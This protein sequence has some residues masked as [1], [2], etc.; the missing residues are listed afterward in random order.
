MSLERPRV[1]IVTNMYP[2]AER[3]QRGIFVQRQV[4]ALLRT[5]E[6]DVEVAPFS[7]SGAPWRYF[8]EA[9][10]LAPQVR[11][12][13]LVHAHYGL[14][15]IAALS[16]L[17]LHRPL[18]L[19]VHGRD[20][21]HA[22]V[23][24]VTAQIA[25]RAAGVVAVS[26]ELAALCPFPIMDV[27]P[28]GVDVQ[29][30]EPLDRAEARRQLGLPEERRF[31]LFPAHPERPEKRIEAA[32]RLADAVGLT[33]RTY[34]DTPTA[35]VPLWINAADAVIV[36]SAR[37]GYG[38]ACMEALACNVAVLSTP[39]GI[40][41]EVLARVPGTL[42][43]PFDLARWSAH[44]RTLLAD[45]DPHVPGREVAAEQSTDVMARRTLALYHEVLRRAAA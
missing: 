11:R 29:R 1:L 28:P 34:C 7:A 41:G 2:D 5:G 8:I 21:H 23:R 17:P 43:A 6:V 14:T 30:F 15:G 40:A 32:Q 13:D 37:E 24:Q 20:C 27:I 22:L 36:T 26:R 44:L 12:A 16:A 33:L 18:L 39:V 3:P 25:A 10:K 42:C 4:D 35:E 9:A 38:L 31:L 19:T 45:A